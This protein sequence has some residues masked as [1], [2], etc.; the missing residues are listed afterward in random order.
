[1]LVQRSDRRGETRQKALA[2][3]PDTVIA[4]SVGVGC[5][6]GLRGEKEWRKRSLT[7]SNSFFDRPQEQGILKV[8]LDIGA[9][10]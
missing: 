10:S 8:L 1:M 7:N 2:K 6:R 9:E 3:H 4:F 5:D